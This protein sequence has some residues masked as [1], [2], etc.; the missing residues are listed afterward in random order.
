MTYCAGWKYK[1]SVYLLADTAATKSVPPAHPRSSFGE[2]HAQVRRAHVEESL[3]KLVP[4]ADG[5]AFAFAG[6]VQL[7]TAIGNHLRNSYAT[8]MSTA[9]LFAGLTASV[10][11]FDQIGR[12][13]V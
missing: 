6:D 9:D 3:L 11:P 5:V 1:D 7:A 12:A 10:G 2:L 8:A 4:I 13:H